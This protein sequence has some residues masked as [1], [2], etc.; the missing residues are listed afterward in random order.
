MPAR[1]CQYF[2]GPA[3]PRERGSEN[4]G[5]RPRTVI[6]NRRPSFRAGEE[7][8][9]RLRQGGRPGSPETSLDWGSPLH[10]R[11]PPGKQWHPQ[12][13][14]EVWTAGARGDSPSRSP[15]GSNSLVS[16]AHGPVVCLPVASWLPVPD[17]VPRG[18]PDL[19]RLFAVSDAALGTALWSPLSAQASH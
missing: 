8:A 12:A 10:P 7:G 11:S 15:C 3:A 17:H 16:V 9:C 4:G 6:T 13:G 19:F 18:M 5:E 2:V 14:E 1:G